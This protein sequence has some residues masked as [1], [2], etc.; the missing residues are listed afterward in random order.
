MALTSDLEVIQKVS[1]TFYTFCENH[2]E[3][4]M[5]HSDNFDLWSIM[6][7]FYDSSPTSNLALVCS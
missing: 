1:L 4:W 5:Y 2:P 7:K 6:K 3:L